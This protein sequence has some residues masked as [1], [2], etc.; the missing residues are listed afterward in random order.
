MRVA[1]CISGQ[2]RDIEL[3]VKQVQ[4]NILNVNPE[5]QIDIFCHAWQAEEGEDWDTAQPNQKHQVGIAKKN[6]DELILSELKPKR[7][8]FEPQ[9]PFHNFVG[10][11][12]TE[13]T[14]KQDALASNFYSVMMANNLKKEYENSQGFVYDMVVRMR[15]DLWFNE[16]IF[17]SCYLD[18]ANGRIVVP[19]NY[20]EDQNN[21]AWNEETKSMVDVFAISSS[22]NMD[23]YSRTFIQMP[24]VNAATSP[25]FGEVYLGVNARIIHGLSLHLADIDLDLIRRKTL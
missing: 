1:I 11:F 25:P 20:Q 5:H 10:N 22:A 7:W 13:P 12:R 21:V 23:K 6:T 17:L 18:V 16:P 8:L 3:G 4:D 14:A 19:K 2:P 24:V 15:Y 9:I